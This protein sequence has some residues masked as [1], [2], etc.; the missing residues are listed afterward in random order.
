MAKA[1]GT[2]VPRAFLWVYVYMYVR[3]EVL[4]SRFAR[5]EVLLSRFARKEVLLSRF[6]LART[7]FVSRLVKYLTKNSVQ[8]FTAPPVTPST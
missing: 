8:P 2:E 7:N 4:L 5:K 1:P 3:K 6:A